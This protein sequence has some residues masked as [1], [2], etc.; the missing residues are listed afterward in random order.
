MKIKTMI[1]LLLISTS[2]IKGQVDS[3]SLMGYSSGNYTVALNADGELKI[4]KINAISGSLRYYP[5]IKG[6][7]KKTKIDQKE[8]KELFKYINANLDLEKQKTINDTGRQEIRMHTM[9]ALF[10]FYEKGKNKFNI[11]FYEHEPLS[12]IIENIYRQ[13][14]E[15]TA[16]SN[17]EFRYWD[18]TKLNEKILHNLSID[19]IVIELRINESLKRSPLKKKELS[20][21]RITIKTEK[22]LEI[23]TNE[24]IGNTKKMNPLKNGNYQNISCLLYTSDAADE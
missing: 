12:K 2:Q 4:A 9:E 11:S 7:T 15:I 19:S 21:K 14:K 13:V 6:Y 16:I 22:D 24:L 17:S 3:I 18:T 20:R 23:L 5:E 1:I 8:T 10:N